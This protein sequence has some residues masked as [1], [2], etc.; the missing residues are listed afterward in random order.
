MI[1]K[2][3]K[4]FVDSVDYFKLFRRGAF[5]W[6]LWLTTETIFWAMTLAENSTDDTAGTALLI[7]AILG[8]VAG[9]QAWVLKIYAEGSMRQQEINK[10]IEGV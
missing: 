1:N 4:L 8:P 6:V 7:G 9:V 3:F 5:I 10:N 2:H